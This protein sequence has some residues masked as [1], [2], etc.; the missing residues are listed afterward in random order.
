MCQNASS[1]SKFKILLMHLTEKVDSFNQLEVLIVRFDKLGRVNLE[2][3]VNF[4]KIFSKKR[5]VTTLR[6][7][8]N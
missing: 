3:Q 7:R 1:N 5:H 8:T 2:Y 6:F 4:Q